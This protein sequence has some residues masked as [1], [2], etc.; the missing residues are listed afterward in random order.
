MM[1][2]IVG[3][4]ETSVLYIYRLVIGPYLARFYEKTYKI[5]IYLNKFNKDERKNYQV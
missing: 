1:W 2:K 3:A 4:L 5:N